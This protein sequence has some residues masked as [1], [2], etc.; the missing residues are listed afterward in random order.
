[1]KGDRASPRA[2][3]GSPCRSPRHAARRPPPLHRRRNVR[4][5]RTQ[6]RPQ[7]R[8]QHH[9]STAAAADVRRGTECECKSLDHIQVKEYSQSANSSMVGRRIGTVVWLIGVFPTTPVQHSRSGF[10]L[11]TGSRRGGRTP[12]PPSPGTDFALPSS[13]SSLSLPP[14]LFCS[15]PLSSLVHGSCPLPSEPIELRRNGFGATPILPSGAGDVSLQGSS[16]I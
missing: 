15:S 2:H 4:L 3:R 13:G 12:T 11:E 9:T 10:P 14:F 5:I 16:K 7:S 1:M 8:P 6:M